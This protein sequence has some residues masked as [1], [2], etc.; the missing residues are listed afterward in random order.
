MEAETFYHIYNRGNNRQI[1]YFEEENYH[2]FMRKFTK[3]LLPCIDLYA[4]CLMPNHFHF[5]IKLKREHLDVSEEYMKMVSESFKVFFM[6]YAKS[7]NKKYKRTGSLFQRKFKSKPVLEE[8]YFTTIVQ[9]FHFNPVKAGLCKKPK[10]WKF[11][12]YNAI[13]STKPTKLKRDEVLEWFGGCENFIKIHEE[14]QLDIEM[15]ETLLFK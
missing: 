12:S 2:Y 11:S 8:S 6:S 14:R 15:I 7:I 5:L 10:D 9:Y 4:Y 13:V 3:H 1:I